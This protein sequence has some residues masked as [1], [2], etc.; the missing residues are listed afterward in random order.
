MIKRLSNS[1]SEIVRAPLPKDDPTRRKPD[2]TRAQK[3]L[4][5]WGPKVSLEE[6]LGATIADF[7]KRLGISA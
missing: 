6:G 1:K 7:R 4:N 5:N 3:L 2:I